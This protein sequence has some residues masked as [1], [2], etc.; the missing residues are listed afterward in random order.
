MSLL[1]QLDQDLKAAMLDRDEARKRAIRSVKTAVSNAQVEKRASQ[2]RDTMLTDDEVIVVINKQAKQ[3]RE[4]IAEF[5]RAGRNDLVEQ[6][7]AEL[8]VLETYLPGQLD[9]AEITEVLQEII[10][11]T[12][13]SGSKEIGLVMRPAMARFAGRADGKVVNQIARQL[14]AESA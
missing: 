6:E 11:E 7:Q 4:S 8:L 12:G 13:A 1:D 9:K 3:R 14:L 2:G 10:A 5:S